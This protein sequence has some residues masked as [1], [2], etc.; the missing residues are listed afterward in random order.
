MTSAGSSGWRKGTLMEPR[1]KTR[2]SR[3]AKPSP[4]RSQRQRDFS[5][6]GMVVL[7]PSTVRLTLTVP[8]DSRG[9]FARGA[10]S[11]AEGQL[12]P[13][14]ASGAVG[15]LAVAVGLADGHELRVEVVVEG[16]PGRRGGV[17]EALQLV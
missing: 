6:A 16:G 13:E 1:M 4:R 17:E 5:G 7:H 2:K 12:G 11:S 15:A 3:T 8:S 9:T 14:R 10:L